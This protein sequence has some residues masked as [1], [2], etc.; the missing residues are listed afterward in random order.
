MANKTAEELQAEIDRLRQENLDKQAIIEATRQV[1]S[2]IEAQNSAP[3]DKPA[4]VDNTSSQTSPNNEPV[5]VFTKEDFEKK[6]KEEVYNTLSKVE[7]I[8]IEQEK[9][10]NSFYEANPDLKGYE[11]IVQ[12]ATLRVGNSAKTLAEQMKL[13]AEEARRIISK[14]TSKPL[15]HAEGGAVNTGG[16][17]P[18]NPSEETDNP[19]DAFAE[20]VSRR[21]KGK[22][23]VI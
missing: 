1:I 5:Q 4:S 10:R 9:L 3:T 8:R 6:V 21:Q 19:L 15:P 7:Q 13:I 16:T 17:P 20:R 23:A 22:Q 18:S 11:E 12:A 2:T 14:L